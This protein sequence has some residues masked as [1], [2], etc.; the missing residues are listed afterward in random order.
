[1]CV[2]VGETGFEHIPKH[3]ASKNEDMLIERYEGK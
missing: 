3:D 2:L 1:M